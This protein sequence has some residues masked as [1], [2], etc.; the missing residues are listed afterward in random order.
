ME[1][2]PFGAFSLMHFSGCIVEGVVLRNRCQGKDWLM[3][4]LFVCNIGMLDRMYGEELI[5]TP[6]YTAFVPTLSLSLA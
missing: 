2:N 5:R 3:L 1:M 6:N 4:R